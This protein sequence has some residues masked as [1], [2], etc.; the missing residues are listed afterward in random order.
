MTALAQGV[1]IKLKPVFMVPVTVNGGKIPDLLGISAIILRNAGNSVVSL[2]NGMYTL[3]QYETLSLNVTED[4]GAVMDVLDVTVNF[5][6]GSTNK[7]EIIIL[8]AANC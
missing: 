8:K 1:K 7:L 2:E 6:G 3:Q 4:C 5:T